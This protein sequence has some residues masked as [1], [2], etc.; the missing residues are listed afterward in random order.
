MVDFHAQMTAVLR[1]HC[2]DQFITHNFIPV[3]DTNADVFAIAAPLDFPSYDSYPLGRTDV[4]LH[5]RL[6]RDEFAKFQRTGHPDLSGLAL[7]QTRGL[8]NGSFWIMEQQPGPVNW[9]YANPAPAPGMIRLWSFE[10][11]AHGADCVSF[12]RW[13]QA[14]FAQEQMHAGLRKPDDSPSRRW[15]EFD[16]CIHEIN[17][18]A[19]TELATAKASVAVILDPV[20]EWVTDI[21]RQGSDYDL[22][23]LEF[24][25][26]SALRGL[27][28]DVDI[29]SADTD[30]SGYKIIV[31]P[32]LAITN[33]DFAKRA[34]ESGALFVFGP[35]SGAKTSDFRIPATLA[36]GPLAQH[37]GATVAEVETLRKELPLNIS[38]QGHTYTATAWR[39]WLD[40][41]DTEVLGRYDDGSAAVVRHGQMIY[42]ATLPSEHFWSDFLAALCAET[43]VENIRLPATL[44]LRQRGDVTFAFNY[45]AEAAA[46]P[47]QGDERFVVGGPTIDAFGVAAW[48]P[49]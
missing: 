27:G 46:L 10:A 23:M 13:R 31:A 1:A 25:V 16:S 4:I 44:R 37:V 43:G 2:G 24:R 40:C 33:D 38:W 14:P 45:G 35:R 6:P 15:A 48:R 20:S 47:L 30:F 49:R 29:I 34:T 41:A 17:A 5:G 9:A 39:E 42:V 36:P 3:R 11:F 12:F 8:G 32:C 19:L 7:D 18:L 21:E 28:L 26:Y 22:Q